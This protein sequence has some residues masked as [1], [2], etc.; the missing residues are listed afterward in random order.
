MS[1]IP[2]ILVC[3]STTSS[4]VEGGGGVDGEKDLLLAHNLSVKTD[5]LPIRACKLISTWQFILFY[6][7]SIILSSIVSGSDYPFSESNIIL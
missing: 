6:F 2:L 3:F 4:A 5:V 1:G 7:F